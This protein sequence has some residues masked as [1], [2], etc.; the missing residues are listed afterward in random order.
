MAKKKTSKKTSELS[1]VGMVGGATVGD[2]GLRL[3]C[4]T[5]IRNPMLAAGDA[6][7]NYA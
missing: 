3:R 2:A 7:H 4:H 6:V 5:D 1:G